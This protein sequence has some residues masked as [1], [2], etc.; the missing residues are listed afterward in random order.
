MVVDG[1]YYTKEHEWVK[2]E[3]STATVGIADHA[4]EAL[5]EITYV[6]LPEVDREVSAKD[7]LAVVESTKAASDVYSPISGKVTEVNEALEDEP[8][9]VNEDCYGEGWI[10]KIEMS[11]A[12]EVEQLMTSDQYKDFFKDEV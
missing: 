4:Q 1:L 6:E 8:E 11:D 12:S 2:V 9:K 3:G 7:E 5:G 10:A